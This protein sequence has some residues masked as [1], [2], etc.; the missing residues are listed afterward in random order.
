MHRYSGNLVP[1][2]LVRNIVILFQVK[3]IQLLL[4]TKSYLVPWKWFVAWMQVLSTSSAIGISRDNVPEVRTSVGV[5]TNYGQQLCILQ[6]SW[7]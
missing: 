7:V 1:V 2:V 5:D 3:I 4:I 6:G